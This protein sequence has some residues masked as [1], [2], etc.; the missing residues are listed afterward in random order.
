MQALLESRYCIPSTRF[1]MSATTLHVLHARHTHICHL[2]I[3]LIMPAWA[4]SLTA[5][6]PR[7][8]PPSRARVGPAVPGGA[9]TAAAMPGL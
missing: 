5:G 3:N 6:G 2:D 7:N 9:R 1:N 4:G 8:P